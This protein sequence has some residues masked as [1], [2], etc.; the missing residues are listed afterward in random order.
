MELTALTDLKRAMTELEQMIESN[1]ASL[2]NYARRTDASPSAIE[3]K[4]KEIATL[5][6]AHNLIEK[7]EYDLYPAAILG[8]II[9]EKGNKKMIEDSAL[10][11]L[12]VVIRVRNGKEKVGYIHLDQDLP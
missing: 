12:I 8:W 7:S 9:L 10:S 3:F 2:K 11:K 1:K 4:D 6:K 5:I